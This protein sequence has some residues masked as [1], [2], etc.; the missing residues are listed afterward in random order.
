MNAPTS[1][2][3]QWGYGKGYQHAHQFQD[4]ITSM[5]CLPEELAGREFYKPTGRGVE[6]RIAARLADIKSAKARTDE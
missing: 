6:E 1:A 4:A 3:K 5:R 2:M